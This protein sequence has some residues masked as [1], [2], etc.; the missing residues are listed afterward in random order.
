MPIL[1]PQ[2]RYWELCMTMNDSWGYQY[3]DDHYKSPQQVIDIFVDCISKGGNLLLD[4]GPKGDGTIP[5]EQVHILREL[6]QWTNKHREAIY[7]TR[8]GI[9]YDHYYGP[10]ALSPDSTTLYLYVRDIPKDGKV[11]LKGV[12]NK[13]NRAYVVGEAS[14]LDSENFCSVYWSEYPGLT[15][16]ELPERALDKY[17]TVIAVL[18]DGPIELFREKTG[19]IESN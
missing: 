9:P 12:K 5:K 6:G 4:I 17:Y 15:Y 14:I 7:G 13:I 16:L 11:V 1:R 2:A 8:R 19:A 3:N 18:L 10:T